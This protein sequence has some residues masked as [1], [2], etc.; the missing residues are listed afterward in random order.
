MS[1]LWAALIAASDEES[2][3]DFVQMAREGEA[4]SLALGSAIPGASART[5]S[6]SSTRAEWDAW[7]DRYD[8]AI[9]MV[10]GMPLSVLFAGCS[11]WDP[12]ADRIISALTTTTPPTWAALR[13]GAAGRAIP[14][15][16]GVSFDW[17]ASVGEANERGNELQQLSSRAHRAWWGECL[18]RYAV[19]PRPPGPPGPPGPRPLPPTPRPP[20]TPTR[21]GGGGLGVALLLAI[22]A[23]ARRRRGRR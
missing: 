10:R 7:T 13:S 3:A 11:G 20:G 22:V 4:L 12:R 5:L 6:T 16:V 21:G 23:Y 17:F 14:P 19:G 1:T 18:T 8:A 15:A 9:P 2:R